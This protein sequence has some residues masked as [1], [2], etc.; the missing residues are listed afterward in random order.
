MLLF[1]LYRKKAYRFFYSS[2]YLSVLCQ[3][4]YDSLRPS[5]ISINHLEVLTEL[6]GILRREM[7]NDQVHS[8]GKIR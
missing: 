5:L 2:D 7:L 3:Y 8:S 4:L 6:C 1:I